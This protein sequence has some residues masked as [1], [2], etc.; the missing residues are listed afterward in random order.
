MRLRRNRGRVLA[1]EPKVSEAENMRYTRAV[2]LSAVY[3]ATLAL[4]WGAFGNWVAEALKASAQ[5]D[6]A[7]AVANGG[8]ALTTFGREFIYPNALGF[9]ISVVWVASKRN[10][11]PVARYLVPSALAGALTIPL[12]FFI[13]YIFSWIWYLLWPVPRLVTLALFA[14]GAVLPGFVTGQLL[15]FPRVRLGQ[16]PAQR[17]PAT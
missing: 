5:T 14:V 9:F 17:A 1:A 2:V 15:R 16:N 7:T 6:A 10:V 12:A 3:F 13:L 11:S 4:L 8:E